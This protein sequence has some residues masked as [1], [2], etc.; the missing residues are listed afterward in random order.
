MIR[1]LPSRGGFLRPIGLG[2]F[3]RDFLAGRLKAPD[4]EDTTRAIVGTLQVDP[5]R[6]AAIDDVRRAYKNF[7][8][9][10]F[11]EEMVARALEKGIELPL[12]EA[13]RRIPQRLTK[14]RAHSFYRYFHILKQLGWMEATGEEEASI[15]GG[16]PGARVERRG[17]TTLVEVPQPRRF[18]RLTLKGLQAEDTLWSDP[19]QAL[20]GYTREQ[21]SAKRQPLPRPGSLPRQPS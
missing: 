12:E 15:L 5:L 6:G 8:F 21:R 2:I 1:D 19:L 10:E 7:L 3:I 20:Y 4:I 11:G 17:E 16:K 14:I 18:Y 9:Q 13:V